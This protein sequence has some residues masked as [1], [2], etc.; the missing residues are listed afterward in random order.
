MKL[1]FFALEPL[2]C[3]SIVSH[4]S[5]LRSEAASTNGK[6]LMLFSG[7]SPEAAP[8]PQPDALAIVPGDHAETIVLALDPRAPEGRG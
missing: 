5:V 1:P 6:R 7:S 3:L 2:N 8:G 4:H